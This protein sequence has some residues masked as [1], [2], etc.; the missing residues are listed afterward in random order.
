METSYTI[1]VLFP[2]ACYC[3]TNYFIAILV[4]E[5]S[6][7]LLIEGTVDGHPQLVV[8]EKDAG[9]RMAHLVVPSF[10]QLQR[11][12]THK[13]SSIH[14]V[15]LWNLKLKASSGARRFPNWG[16]TVTDDDFLVDSILSTCILID[17]PFPFSA[18]AR[19]LQLLCQIGVSRTLSPVSTPATKSLHK[20]L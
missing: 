16:R 11:R 15:C 5:Y 4:L 2:P 3:R 7:S 8:A 6:L 20:V 14:D 17:H 9:V 18:I 12:V 13:L 1:S 10:R 19:D